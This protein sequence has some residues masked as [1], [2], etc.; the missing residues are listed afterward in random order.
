MQDIYAVLNFEVHNSFEYHSQTVSMQ[1]IPCI[2]HTEPLSEFLHCGHSALV[3][4]RVV[5]Q[6]IT[7]HNS[8]PPVTMMRQTWKCI[9]NFPH[10]SF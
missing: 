1:F 2:N 10:N 4:T 8:R 9:R 3:W 7:L 5:L 6:V